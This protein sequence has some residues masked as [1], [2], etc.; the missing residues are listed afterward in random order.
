M[1]IWSSRRRHNYLALT[2]HWIVIEDGILVLKIALVGFHRLRGSHKGE[3]LARIVYMLL[4]RA[5]LTEKVSHSAG[6]CMPY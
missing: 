6:Y 3:R 1:D 4:E 5:E 2:A